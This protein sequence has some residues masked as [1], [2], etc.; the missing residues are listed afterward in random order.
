MTSVTEENADR[1][2][3]FYQALWNERDL[4]VIPEWIAPEYVGYFTSRPEPVR[5]PAG[6]RSFANDLFSAFP[7]LR[8]SIQDMVARDDRVVSRVHLT[9]THLGPMQGYAP[10]GLRVSTTFAAIERYA[11]GLCVE[12][13]VYADDLG[14]ARQIRALPMPGSVAERAAQ[15]VHRAYG[16]RVRQS[17]RDQD[18]GPRRM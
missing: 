17:N 11:G 10:T 7:D 14:L 13:W 16:W 12:E 18:A 8:M 15:W 6:F 3:R 4:A 1:T 5:G 2:R 9:G